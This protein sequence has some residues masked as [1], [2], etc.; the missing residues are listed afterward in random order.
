MEFGAGRFVQCSSVMIYGASRDYMRFLGF[1]FGG[2]VGF[3]YI[4][5]LLR[6]ARRMHSAY[7]KDVGDDPSARQASNDAL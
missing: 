1:S 7:L 6:E 4:F 2:W 5:K 3:S